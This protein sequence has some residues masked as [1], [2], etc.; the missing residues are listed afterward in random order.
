MLWVA[1]WMCLLYSGP[2]KIFGVQFGEVRVDP[3]RQREWSDQVLMDGAWLTDTEEGHAHQK[4]LL[5]DMKDKDFLAADRF[6]I[7]FQRVQ[8]ERLGYGVPTV[9]AEQPDAGKGVFYVAD[10]PLPAGAT[11]SLFRCLFVRADLLTE[12]ASSGTLKET[13]LCDHA[14]FHWPSDGQPPPARRECTGKLWN[15]YSIRLGGIVS[16]RSKPDWFCLPVGERSGEEWFT[17]GHLQPWQVDRALRAANREVLVDWRG[18]REWGDP[19]EAEEQPHGG[20]LLYHAHMMN[21]PSNDHTITVAMSGGGCPSPSEAPQGV[22]ETRLC[23]GHLEAVTTRE[24]QPGQELVWC[25]GGGYPRDYVVGSA[26]DEVNSWGWANRVREL[27]SVLEA[28]EDHGHGV[29]DS[30]GSGGRG[31]NGREDGEGEQLGQQQR[32][33]HEFCVPSF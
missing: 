11:V 22:E 16:D 30:G 32:E 15:S 29:D 8:F 17:V 23:A 9:V 14:P 20:R 12:W 18:G 28:Q 2:S 5:N 10:E 25:Y 4:S 33:E 21:E 6:A 31:A 3:V 27:T 7:A 24:V 1:F 19:L 26:C 13:V